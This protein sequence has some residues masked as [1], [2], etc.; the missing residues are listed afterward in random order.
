MERG[1]TTRQPLACM[2]QIL[3]IIHHNGS[4]RSAPATA[5]RPSKVTCNYPI[6]FNLGQCCFFLNIFLVAQDGI[7]RQQSAVEP[8]LVQLGGR[9]GL[10]RGWA[11]SAD[12]ILAQ[13]G[14]QGACPP[15]GCSAR[16]QERVGRS[17]SQTTARS[18]TSAWLVYE[19]L[20]RF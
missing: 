12:R 11:L 4:H 17:G 18:V 5:T 6:V 2:S 16:R 19:E 8:T 7:H 20:A 14:G 15:H 13:K 9:Q 10:H 1:Q 3:H